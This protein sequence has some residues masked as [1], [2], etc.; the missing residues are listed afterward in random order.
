[1]DAVVDE[2]FVLQDAFD[3]FIETIEEELL[4]NPSSHVLAVIQKI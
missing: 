2:Y 4:S 3:E 1:M